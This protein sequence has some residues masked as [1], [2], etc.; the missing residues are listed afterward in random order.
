LLENTIMAITH[1]TAM[2]WGDRVVNDE[3]RYGLMVCPTP[4]RET[5]ARRWYEACSY[6]GD[7][8]GPYEWI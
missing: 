5:A 3:V 8:M 7:D 2:G 4:S 1:Q 6:A